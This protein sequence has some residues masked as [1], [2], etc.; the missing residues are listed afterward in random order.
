M[1]MGVLLLGASPL[2]EQPLADAWR[3]MLEEG[4]SGRLAPQEAHEVEPARCG[5]RPVS[6]CA[7]VGQRERGLCDLRAEPLL[8]FLPG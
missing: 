2:L 3:V 7:D 1:G 4:R 8:K 6:D 5:N